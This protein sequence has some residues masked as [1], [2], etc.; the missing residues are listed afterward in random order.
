MLPLVLVRRDQAE[1]G[2]VSIDEEFVVQVSI[3]SQTNQAGGWR[4]R[5]REPR[6][7]A[8]WR[9]RPQG[10][11]D[12]R[13]SWRSGGLSNV[14]PGFAASNLLKLRGVPSRMHRRRSTAADPSGD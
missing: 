6:A 11:A 14:N 7:R 5:R 4:Q 12:D 8:D 9:I 1:L 10:N 3:G 13:T 2:H